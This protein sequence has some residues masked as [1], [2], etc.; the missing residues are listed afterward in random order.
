VD[1]EPANV[2]PFPQASDAV[3][4]RHLRAFVAVADDLNF[5]RAAERLY[6]SQ[7][8][9]SRQIRALEHLIGCEL[10]RRSTHRVQL[11]LAGEALLDHARKVLAEVEEAISRTQAVGGELV[12]RGNRLWQ[13]L[14]D[15]S[16]SAAGLDDLRA[17]FETMHAQFAPPP[18]VSV[19][20]VN[21]GGVP[22]LLVE[23]EATPPATLLYLHGGGFV[24]GSAFG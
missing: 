8:A 7:P 19:R 4:L 9:L 12:G 6:L 13:P 15:L 10:F 2:L 24:L 3:E 17:A 23:P 14:I 20:P 22:A 11:T 18:E 21:A 16:E 5:G 1:V